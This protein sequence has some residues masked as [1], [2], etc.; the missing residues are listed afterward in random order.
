MGYAEFALLEP[1]GCVAAAYTQRRRLEPKTGGTLWII[2]QPDDTTEFT[3]SKGLD[4]PATIILTDVP[5]SIKRLVSATQAKVIE[6]NNLTIDGYEFAGHEFTDGK[7]FDDIVM[8]NTISA[9][10]VGQIARLIARR[11]T[12]N[13]VGT[14]PLDGLVQVDFG[15][16]HYDYIAFVGNNTLDIAASYG[17]RHNRCDLRPNGTAVF[18]GV[19]GRWDKCTFNERSN[20]LKGQS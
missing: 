16:L 17:E 11:G 8:L 5:A 1:W 12:L 2:G 20:C 19:A 9:N 13:L 10:V 15:R 6:R 14:K 18:V 4:A 7:G 3:F